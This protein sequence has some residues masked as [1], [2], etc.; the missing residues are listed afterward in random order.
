[1]MNLFL[2]QEMAADKLREVEKST[3]QKIANQSWKI[4]VWHNLTLLVCRIG[5]FQTD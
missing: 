4:K 3:L 2:A 5:R 1:M